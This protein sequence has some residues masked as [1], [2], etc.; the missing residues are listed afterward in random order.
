MSVSYPSSAA[1]ATDK[2]S[3]AHYRT[4]PFGP[5]HQAEASQVCVKEH[6]EHIQF[7]TLIWE[8]DTRWCILTWSIV[9]L[10]FEEQAPGGQMVT[11]GRKLMEIS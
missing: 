11:T 8:P 9:L 4:T 5:N 7:P 2:S 10:L 6:K 1:I 3:K